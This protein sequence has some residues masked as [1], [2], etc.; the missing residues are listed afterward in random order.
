MPVKPLDIFCY[1]DKQRFTQFGSMDCANWYG[2]RAEHGKLQQAL[3]PAMG[4]KHIDFLG[5]NR[6]IF[7][8]TP[9][10]IFK[11]IDFAYIVV[12]SRV[13]QE[14]KFYNQKLIGNVSLTGDIWADYLPVGNSVYV[15]MTDGTTIW[16]IT[17]TGSSV[18]MEAVTDA[19]APT[20]PSYV[21]AF[22]NRFVVSKAGTPDYFL[23]TVNVT[24]GPSAC[25]TFGGGS[26][27]SLTN[28]ASGV[29]GQLGVLHNQLYIFCD[30]TTDVWSNI[31]TQI[32]IGGGT[33]VEFPWK[34]NS[35]Y[36][37]DYGIFDPHSLDIDFGMMV[38]LAKNRNGLVTF[39]ASNG[40][41]PVSISTQAV[42]V[43]LQQQP[44]NG[45]L[46]PFLVGR[47]IGF[48]Y[49]YEDSIFY[50]V[51]ADQ[52]LN[53]ENVSV[54]DEANC[55]EFNFD[56]KTWHR[57]IEVDQSPNRIL[58]HIYFNG[59]HLVTIQNDNAM[60]QMAGNIYYNED[61]TPSTQTF[62]QYPMRYELITPHIF[63]DTALGEP[64]YIEFQTDYVEIDF[65]WG[66][67]TFFRSDAPFLN[68]VFVIAENS[69]ADNPTYIT[70]ET[71]LNFIIKEGTNVPDFQS[72]FYNSL[73]KPH[74]ELYYSDDGGMTF[75][76]ADLR[77]FSP[78]G[79]YRWRMRWYELGPSRNR[80]Y[81]LVCVS[82]APIVILG[83]VHDVKRI[84]GGAN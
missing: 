33:L 14:D 29:I 51:L 38:W 23:T 16:F 41:Q 82:S 15:F 21:R 63:S 26:P 81:K 39:M 56:T 20:N 53:I 67:Q 25:F 28:R 32:D 18:T 59:L 9:R 7:D 68:T 5:V 57:C 76:S 17:E 55:L 69:P 58:D 64:G 30:F 48:L 79:A 10:F 54:D 60:Y 66:N 73:F 45:I 12:G 27:Y 49:Q 50:R 80:C 19:Q 70:D 78:L 6:L 61:Y 3:Y 62:N 34:L 46:N 44:D 13:F 43:L 52:Y 22:G 77:E 83:A 40:Q 37:W 1:Y 4:R 74:I 71:G 11:S 2:V 84:S 24:G 8:D 72:Q 31:P 75:T 65:V 42:N 47:V 36:N 35:S